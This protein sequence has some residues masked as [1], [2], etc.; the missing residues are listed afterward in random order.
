MTLTDPGPIKFKTKLYRPEGT[1]TG[2]FFPFPFDTQKLFGT[3]ANVKVE[4]TID[5]YTWRGL[6]AN[7]GDPTH[8]VVVRREI[9]E[10]IKK[11]AGDPIDVII[12]LDTK[13]RIVEVPDDIQKALAK[14]KSE[15]E[16]FQSLSFSHQKEY[17]EWVTSA[18]K[19]ETRDSRLEKMIEMLRN[20]KKG[21]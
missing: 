10:A 4:I 2:T 17:V 1:G 18:K 16:F 15:N 19:Q 9:R 3:Q 7:M 21:K 11:D 13:P 5:N 12:K 20:K 6:L 14:H 8:C